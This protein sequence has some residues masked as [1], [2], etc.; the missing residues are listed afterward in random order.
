MQKSYWVLYAIR[1]ILS[2]EIVRDMIVVDQAYSSEL[3]HCYM[4]I[5][6]TGVNKDKIN[7]I[8]RI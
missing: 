4:S 1:C 5:K 6:F 3:S 7:Q 8:S 2:D